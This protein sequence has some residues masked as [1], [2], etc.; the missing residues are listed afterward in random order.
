MRTS[1]LATIL[2]NA[3]VYD[4]WVWKDKDAKETVSTVVATISYEDLKRLV[5]DAGEAAPNPTSKRGR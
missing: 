5:K 3:R 4:G 1:E 2:G